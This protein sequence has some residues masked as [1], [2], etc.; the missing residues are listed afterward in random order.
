MELSRELSDR[1]Y[2]RHPAR[3]LP[4]EELYDG[5]Q[6][7]VR[8]QNVVV[9]REAG[10]EQFNYTN[11]CRFDNRWDL[12]SLLARGLILDP[13]ARRVVATPFPKFFNFGEVLT[14][15]PN[16]P[17][18]I[19]E[20]ID[21]SLGI[22][23]HHQG[24][25][26]VA[27]KGRLSSEQA[28]WATRYLNS[29]VTT[30]D[31]SPG[32]TYLVEIVYPTNR[33]VI[34]YGFEALFLLGAYDADGHELSR[35]DLERVAG[36]TG[37]RPVP[38][39]TYDS[40]DQ[41]LDVAKRLPRDREGFVV[42]FRGGLRIKLKGEEYCRIHRLVTYCTPLALW[43]AMMNSQDMDAIRRELPEEMMADFDTIRRLLQSQLDHLILEVRTAVQ[44]AA[45]LTD[46]DVG[47]LIQNPQS[48]L[49]DSQRKFLFMARKGRFFEFVSEPGESRPRHSWRSGR[50]AM[51][52]PATSRPLRLRGSNRKA[53]D[54]E[55]VVNSPTV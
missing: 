33:I 23:F 10:L 34:P 31:L 6:A 30:Q 11:G 39:H 9:S 20:K 45:Q 25:W 37:L 43:E 8:A 53:P 13:I 40:I 52:C 24:R 54:V 49:T 27:T 18:E 26:Q 29:N 36:A 12:H 4:F 15:L 42:R 48:G 47:V 50:C 41:L 17:F 32:T 44:A 22:V 38:A 46:K 51:T 35:V 5:L 14:S 16:E 21:G 19:T 2:G 28:E 7:A 55:T 3:E 1:V